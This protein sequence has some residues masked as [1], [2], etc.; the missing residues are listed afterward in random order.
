MAAKARTREIRLNTFYSLGA[1]VVILGALCKMIHYS[2]FGIIDSNWILTAGLLTEAAV[3]IIY[4]FFS[5]PDGEYDWERVYPELLDSTTATGVRKVKAVQQPS[6]EEAEVSL[7]AKLD[8]MLS[9]AKLDSS[10]LEKLR[11][12][13]ENF[14]TAVEGI[15]K[16]AD[17]SLATAKYK[18]QLSLAS[19][20]MESLNALYQIQL[21]NGKRYSEANQLLTEGLTKSRH[22]SES[23]QQQLTALTANLNNLNKVYGGMLNAM[24]A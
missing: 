17:A 3:F 12:G 5:P 8:E 10:L 22:D 11:S 7:S 20:H 1:A 18:D 14:G 2:P 16:T 9:K 4:A 15:N 19:S 23:F 24:K 13:I 6:I 21:E